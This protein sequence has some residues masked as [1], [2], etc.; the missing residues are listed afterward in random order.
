MDQRFK[1]VSSILFIL[2][3]FSLT[4]S[5]L[6]EEVRLYEGDKIEVEDSDFHLLIGK[7]LNLSIS[8]IVEHEN[9]LQLGSMNLSVY[10]K[11][12]NSNYLR[13]NNT[14]NRYNPGSPYRAGEPVLELLT[15]AP[16]GEEVKFRFEGFPK[17]ENGSYTLLENGSQIK[18]LGQTG[19]FRWNNS[20]WSVKNYTVKCSETRDCETTEDD[21]KPSISLSVNNSSPTGQEQIEIIVS[22]SDSD[23]GVSEVRIFIDGSQGKT[24]QSN[25]CSLT[26]GP[27]DPDTF[28]SYKAEAEDESG[29]LAEESGTLE[30]KQSE[31]ESETT[32]ENGGS[33]GGGGGGGITQDPSGGTGENESSITLGSEKVQLKG[34][35]GEIVEAKINVTN[36]GSASN[37]DIDVKQINFFVDAPKEIYLEAG[38]TKQINISADFTGASSSGHEGSLKLSNEADSERLPIFLLVTTDKREFDMEVNLESG[39]VK[40]G[41]LPVFSLT[42]YS[43]KESTSKVGKVSLELFNSYNEKVYEEKLAVGEISDAKKKRKVI[44]AELPRGSY[45]LRAT[46]TVNNQT[47]VASDLFEVKSVGITKNTIDTIRNDTLIKVLLI[48]LGIAVIETFFYYYEW[49]K[50][51][52]KA[53]QKSKTISKLTKKRPDSSKEKNNISSKEMPSKSQEYSIKHENKDFGDSRRPD[54]RSDHRSKDKI[55]SRIKELKQEAE[56]LENEAQNMKDKYE[57]GDISRKEY[58]EYLQNKE[59]EERRIF[60]EVEKL[61]DKL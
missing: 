49:R 36:Q 60:N 5:A 41:S 16:Q 18:K 51:Y 28:H 30:I 1:T 40:S 7:E 46:T 52:K 2:I 3:A 33:S 21:T 35:P 31:E 9:T 55:K 44:D 17:L 38:E 23:T 61:E 26:V 39:F 58:R 22:S 15:S 50:F 45:F 56:A 14:L 6:A 20:K 27:F 19:N 43:L 24:C 29:N 32:G 12:S 11:D 48:L 54:D 37:Y 25:S 53:K 59:Q 34:S 4:S 42:T 10:S 57:G 47:Y 13:T 8:K